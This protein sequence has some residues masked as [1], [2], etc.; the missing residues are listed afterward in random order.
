MTRCE[1]TCCVR[2]DALNIE[3]HTTSKLGIDAPKK[4]AGEGFKRPS[5][6]LIKMDETVKAKVKKLF[7]SDATDAFRD[8]AKRRRVSGLQIE[9]LEVRQAM[10]H[11]KSV[12]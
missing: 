6:L 7:E 11:G 3:P 10:A 1:R 4:L 9:R 12:I 5:P 8:G 2:S